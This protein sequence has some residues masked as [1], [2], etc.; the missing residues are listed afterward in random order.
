MTHGAVALL[1]THEDFQSALGFGSHRFGIAAVVE[2]V[3]GRISRD[4][5]AFEGSDG[6]GNHVDT[7]LIGAPR[8]LEKARV[9]RVG[10]QALHNAIEGMRHFHGIG[11]RA[12]D[13]F[14]EAGCAAIPE[15]QRKVRGI[16]YRW[17]MARARF[18]ANTF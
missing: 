8:F 1:G 14:F 3:E 15:L 9:F 7:D 11:H 13:L 17:S 5:R 2:L 10:L 6:L 18:L 16:D 12:L 4:Y